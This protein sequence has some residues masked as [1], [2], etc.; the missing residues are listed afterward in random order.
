MRIEGWY[1]L[2]VDFYNFKVCG[3]PYPA[4]WGRDSSLYQKPLWHIQLTDSLEVLARWE[5]IGNSFN[6]TVKESEADYDR[7]FLYA[8]D[9]NEERYLLLAVFGPNA[10]KHPELRN[11][12]STLKTD[13][14]EKWLEGR[15]YF[16]P[17]E[18][19]EP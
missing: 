3:E 7:W 4:D 6:R 10:H 19:Y 9:P 13:V 11:Y 2:Y 17:P 16:E 8:K 15:Q 14:V 5:K 12:L 18:D 1:D